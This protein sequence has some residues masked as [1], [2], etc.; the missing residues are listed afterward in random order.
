MYIILRYSGHVV[1][2]HSRKRAALLSGTEPISAP[3]C[4]C[5]ISAAAL[6][7]FVFESG[8]LWAKNH[9]VQNLFYQENQKVKL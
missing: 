1:R 9:L 7:N 4:Y 3:C 5:W 2:C 6:R 8:L